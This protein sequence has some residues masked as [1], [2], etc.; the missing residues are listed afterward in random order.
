MITTDELFLSPHEVNSFHDAVF[1]ATNIH[2]T[3]EEL[4]ELF[5][6]LPDNLMDMAHCWGLSDTVFRDEVYIWITT[7]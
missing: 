1:E 2:Y 5:F 7:N 3:D 6:S 4:K